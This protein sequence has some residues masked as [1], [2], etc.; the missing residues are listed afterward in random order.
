MAFFHIPHGSGWTEDHGYGILLRFQVSTSYDRAANKSTVTITPQAYSNGDYQYR[1]NMLNNSYLTANGQ[2]LIAATGSGSGGNGLYFDLTSDGWRDLDSYTITVNHDAQGNASLNISQAF[3]LN[4]NGQA[5]SFVNHSSGSQSW[6]ETPYVDYTLI[7][8][9][10]PGS[11]VTVTKAGVTLQNGASIRDGDVLTVNFGAAAG[12]V[13]ETHTVNGET[14]ESGSTVTVG[15]NVTVAATASAIPYTLSISSGPGTE[16][17]VQRISSPKQGAALGAL[18]D[19]SALYDGDVLRASAEAATGYALTSA[20]LNGKPIPENHT[21]SGDVSVAATAKEYVDPT[22]RFVLTISTGTGAGATVIRQNEK[23]ISGAII[24][25]GDVLSVYFSA[26]AG[27][28]LDSQTVNGSPFISGGTVTVS[29]DVAV[30]VTATE[31]TKIPVTIGDLWHDKPSFAQWESDRVL[32]INGSEKPPFVRF[33]NCA[34]SRA[35]VVKAEYAGSEWRCKVPNIMLQYAGDMAVSVVVE[36]ENGET[37]E[38]ASAVYRVKPRVKPQDYEYTENIGYIN[39]VAKSAEAEKLLEQ[40]RIDVEAN[41][42]AEAWAVGTRNGVP[43]GPT[44]ETFQNNA[45]FYADVAGQQAVTGGFLYF[46]I[47]EYGQLVYTR[48]EDVIYDFRLEN[49]RLIVEVETDE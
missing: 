20:T 3:R 4:G 43:V 15:G 25:A 36:E 45:R 23:L 26:D 19:G 11:T 7:L 30:A 32:V 1:Y 16:V 9:A 17:T 10:G 13:L 49:G 5:R 8:S 27:Y 24:A 37:R 39:W 34:I 33:A 22:T 2:T 44:D 21:V 18:T 35:L 48:T 46:Y 12:F 6:S 38:I 31:D 41:S 29:G 42:R 28:I 14:K 40:M 47:N